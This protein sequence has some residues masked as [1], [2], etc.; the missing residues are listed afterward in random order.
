MRTAPRSSVTAVMLLAMTVQTLLPAG[1][2]PLAAP[3]E[4]AADST[5]IRP[6]A[7]TPSELVGLRQ[8]VGRFDLRVWSGFDAWDVRRPRLDSTGVAFEPGDLRGVPAWDRGGPN[9]DYSRP[10]PL[11][12]PVAWGHIDSLQVRKPGAARGGGMGLALGLLAAVGFAKLVDSDSS[13]GLGMGWLF[14]VPL[15]VGSLVLGTALGSGQR[16]S[17]TVWARP[18]RSMGAPAGEAGATPPPR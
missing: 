8:S 11:V 6:A 7:P 12:S 10:D 17:E 4:A 16:S 15:V 18:A 3:D 14:I 1:T 13:E 5:A 9:G 2:G